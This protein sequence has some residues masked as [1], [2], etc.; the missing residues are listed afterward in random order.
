MDEMIWVV[1]GGLG[2]VIALI[3]LN[4]WLVGRKIRKDIEGAARYQK[5]VNELNARRQA[6]LDQ[7][8]ADRKRREHAAKYEAQ[9][10]SSLRS[11][12]QSGLT[13]QRA[14]KQDQKPISRIKEEAY[15]SANN[16]LTD[17][18]WLLASMLTQSSTPRSEPEPEKT[19][20]GAGGTFDGGGASGDWAS[21]TSSD[22][23]SSCSLSSSSSSSASSDSSSSSSSDSG[24][25]CGSSD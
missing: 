20:Q 10:K 7:I 14:V 12:S 8:E 15:A 9:G 22:S 21:S 11:V 2:A 4:E 6:H 5:S 23:S 3:S 19:L 13:A 17:N 25:S 16:G 1:L 18:D 24:S